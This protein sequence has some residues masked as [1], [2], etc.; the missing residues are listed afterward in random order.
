VRPAAARSTAVGAAVAAA[1]VTLAPP[2][3][4]APGGAPAARPA[5][6]GGVWSGSVLT[7]GSGPAAAVLSFADSRGR[8]LARLTGPSGR[9]GGRLPEVTALAPP[10]TRT[11]RLTSTAGRVRSATAV[12]RTAAPRE[13]VPPLRVVGNRLHDARGPVVLRGLHRY[14][15]EG[16]NAGAEGRFPLDAEIGAMR[17]WGA[18]SARVSVSAP[19]WLGDCGGSAAAA[20]YRSRV[21]ALV[22]SITARG[23]VALVDLHT[24]SL[25]ASACRLERLPLPPLD[26]ALR[27]WASAAALAADPLV[28][29][30]LWNEPHDVTEQQ[31]RSGGP[32]A[33]AGRSYVAAGMQALLDAVRLVAPDALVVVDGPQYGGQP[34]ASPLA[35]DAGVA[36]AAHAYTCPTSVGGQDCKPRPHEAVGALRL[37]DGFGRT[38][39]VLV[40]EFGWPAQDDGRFLA[41]VIAY[42]E[43]R[44]WGWW[45][46]AWDGTTVG[47]FGLVADTG[48]HQPVP[49]GMAVLA[50]LSVSRSGRS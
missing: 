35:R 23:A 44:G 7:S 9:L 43:Q 37:W 3:G 33:D 26:Q 42:A 45:A 46:F 1:L 48:L 13:V 27:F 40:T 17:A 29:L 5:V 21:H 34:P 19:L 31:W 22:R 30:E 18:T 36:Y 16:D 2:A 15:P 32:V 8:V 47:R 6:A 49:A 38:R 12:A 41:S 39:P 20:A 24:A 14:G 10:G 50:G 28:A 25:P 4:G 11:V